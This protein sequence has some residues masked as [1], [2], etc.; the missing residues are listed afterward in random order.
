MASEISYDSLTTAFTS[1]IRAN[2]N[3]INTGLYATLTTV[4]IYDPAEVQ[5]WNT[6]MPAISVNLK[7]TY[8]EM[9]TLNTYSNGSSNLCTLYYEIGCHIRDIKSYSAVIIDMQ[10]FVANTAKALRIDMTLSN[11]FSYIQV[12]GVEFKNTSE[13]ER[14]TYNKDA[15]INVTAFKYF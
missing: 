5:I 2:S 15:I 12:T 13:T 11:T 3:T 14:K 8:E 7:S 4:G 1:Y 9:T 10:K 6:R